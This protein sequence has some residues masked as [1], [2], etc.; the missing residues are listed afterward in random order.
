MSIAAAFLGM[1]P[2]GVNEVPA[3][4]PRKLVL[5]KDCGRMI[6]NL[7]NQDVRPK[8]IMSR[9][10][11]ENA[12]TAFVGT[13]GS[14]NAVLHLLAIAREMGVPLMLEDFDQI[15]SRTPI[16][17]DL[18]PFGKFVAP[19]LERAGG[20]RLFAQRL[21]E[22]ELIK[23]SPTVS[24]SS[25]F[26]EAAKA[27]ETP[28]QKVIYSVQKPVKP[29]G[30]IAILRGQVAPEGCVMKLAGHETEE[31]IGPARVYDSEQAAFDSLQKG[32][33]K[34]GDVVI[35]RYVGPKGA[36]GMPEMLGVTGAIVG[37]GLGDK[38][39]LITD[40]RFSGAT[41]GLMIGHIAP[42]AAVG[43]PIACLKNGDKI[44]IDVKNR[45]LDVDADLEPRR[46]LWQAPQAKYITGAF[47]KY[48]ATVSSA[49]NGA[50]TGFFG[51]SQAPALVASASKAK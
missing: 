23:D 14:T 21:M 34:A 48:A 43:G 20:F 8:Q 3:L 33:I 50:V 10:A 2:M 41:H 47:A 27:K 7:F 28:D 39:A 17:A 44:T 36:P 11:F 49:S 30:G 9:Q 31:F 26:E 24:G 45:R 13:G 18:K 5:A 4:D 12:I 15:S 6:M 19:D 16:I 46:Q 22:A 35:I 38:V 51:E 37:A 29:V 32:E 1:S 40:G 25:L 42:E